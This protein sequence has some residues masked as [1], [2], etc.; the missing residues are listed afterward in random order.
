MKTQTTINTINEFEKT[1][2][3]I[4]RLL[5][6]GYY[7]EHSYNED[8]YHAIFTQKNETIEY[9]IPAKNIDVQVNY[10]NDEAT[11]ESVQINLLLNGKWVFDFDELDPERSDLTNYIDNIINWYR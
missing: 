10:K 7:E 1:Q 4:D 6:N 3:D 11:M 2:E 8:G 9:L 5:D